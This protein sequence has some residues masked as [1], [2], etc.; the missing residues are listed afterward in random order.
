M[1]AREAY[2]IVNED[3]RESIFERY[4]EEQK[5]KALD[6]ALE[7]AKRALIRNIPSKIRTEKQF[8]GDYMCPCCSGEV[9]YSKDEADAYCRHCGQ[10]L[11]WV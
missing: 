8:M 10:E 6:E 3:T 9:W 2:F 7:V 4:T 1:E 11:E 5:V